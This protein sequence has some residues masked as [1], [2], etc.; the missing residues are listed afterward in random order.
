MP[1]PVRAG[2]AIVACV[3][4]PGVPLEPGQ[5]LVGLLDPLR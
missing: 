1:D 4:P 3:G 5:A 2:A